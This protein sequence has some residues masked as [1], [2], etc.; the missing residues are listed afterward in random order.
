V[1]RML[2]AYDGSA[3]ARRALVHAGEFAGPEDRLTV[4]NVMPEPR[5]GAGIGRPAEERNRQWRLLDEARQSMARR[6]I[7][8]EAA[9]RVGEGAAEVL[10]VAD[11]V[12]ADV[13]VVGRRRRKAAHVLGS[14][15]GR[16]VRDAKCDVLV[17]HAD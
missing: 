15:S 16:I 14:I 13:V 3:A 7:E 12:G 8:I 11:D 9:A 2:V 6:G 1:K 10:A 17:V 5:I 4:V